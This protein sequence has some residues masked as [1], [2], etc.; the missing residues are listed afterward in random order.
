MKIDESLI[1]GMDNLG[2]LIG[3]TAGLDAAVLASKL[4]DDPIKDVKVADMDGQIDSGA[5]NAGGGGRV[6]GWKERLAKMREQK[7][8]QKKVIEESFAEQSLDTSK[9]ENLQKVQDIFAPAKGMERDKDG[10]IQID[11]EKVEEKSVVIPKMDKK[12]DESTTS[13][14]ESSTSRD[15]KIKAPAEAAKETASPVKA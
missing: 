5:D 10:K 15:S 6:K 2:N 4:D 14:T 3:N 1:S 13:A 11:K 9:D 8:Q 12:G 7:E